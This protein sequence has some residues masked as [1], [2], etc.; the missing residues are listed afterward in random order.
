MEEK[1]LNLVKSINSVLWGPP[2]MI[3]LVGFGIFAT[4]YLGVP[5]FKGLKIGWAESFGKIFEKN[6]NKKEGSMSSFQSLATAIAAQVGTGNIGGVSGAI[7]TGGPGAVFWMWMT[8]LVGMATITV[9]ASLAQKYRT[10]DE[11]GQLVGGPAYYI[12]KGFENRGLGGLGKALGTIFAILIVLALG[13]IGNMVQSNSISTSVETA[14]GIPAI[15]VGIA[16]SIVSALIFFGGMDRIGKF[17]E[18]V[19]PFMALIYIVGSI[20][21]MVKLR[22]HMLPTFQ[23]IFSE[24]FRFE[25]VAGGVVGYTIKSAIR[26][27]VARGLFSNEAGMGSTPNSHAVADVKHPY[28]QG[29]VAMVGV[30]IDTIVVCS[31]SALVVVASGAYQGDAQ[32]VMITMEAF[33]TVF[34][35]YGS[36]FVATALVFFALTT[37]IGWYYFGEGNI[38]YIFH[39][40]IAVQIYRLIVMV[41]IVVGASRKVELV[42]ELADMFNALMAIPNIIGLVVLSSEARDIMKDY[43]NQVKLGKEL[44]YQYKYE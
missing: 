10:R 30:F 29:A 22:S 5:Q 43:Y 26:Y 20:V 24:A 34:G 31:S 8:A 16:I 28:I 21:A 4:I 12:T 2:M 44:S 11:N 41:F 6:D 19:V 25:A 38:K 18:M 1:V 27:G 35:V 7:A 33:G 39:S 9:E 14:F 37:I 17:A 3:I 23:L 13:F 15:F 42:W 32:G 36:K 40:N